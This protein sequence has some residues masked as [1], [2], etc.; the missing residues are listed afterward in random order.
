MIDQVWN[1]LLDIFWLL[2]GQYDESQSG[3]PRP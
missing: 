3:V 2:L 1:R